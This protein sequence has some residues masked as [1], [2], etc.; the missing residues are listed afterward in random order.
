ML[1]DTRIVLKREKY[2]PTPQEG[3]EPEQA[4]SYRLVVSADVG[5]VLAG[6]PPGDRSIDI[7]LEDVRLGDGLRFMRDLAEEISQ[8]CLGKHP[9]AASFPAGSSRWPFA[10][11]LNEKAY[12]RI[13]KDYEEGYFENPLITRVFDSWMAKLPA[14]GSVLDAGCGH[15][16]PVIS[17]LLEHGFRVTGTDISPA[18]LERARGKYP[19]VEFRQG[20]VS[21][22]EAEAAFDGVC[23]LSSLLYLDPIDLY[24]GIHRLYRALKPGGLLFLY[25]YDT[26]PGWRGNPLAVR[27]R[28]WMWSWTYGMGEAVEALEEHG[29]FKVLASR[30]VTTKD[31][32]E[33][34]VEQWRKDQQE[35]YERALQHY[36]LPGA[37]PPP[38]PD[39]A[40][41]PDNLGYGYAIIARRKQRR[42][43]R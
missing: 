41:P 29:Y 15:G 27:I 43:K 17:R 18:M 34:L 1:P 10:R 14:N 25:A 32:K 8:V 37:T 35:D 11:G 6:D 36:A 42:G 12:D 30:N 40:S 13:S 5:S 9:D 19:Q 22:L 33:G 23:S 2:T 3:Q 39:L 38:A 26:S 20:S 7:H 16:D 4:S 24:Q 28:Q 21:D 31:E